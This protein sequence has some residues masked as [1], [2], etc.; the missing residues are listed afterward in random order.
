MVQQENIDATRTYFM[1]EQ[2][3][4]QSLKLVKRSKSTDQKRNIP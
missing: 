2:I 3:K 1:L 4:W